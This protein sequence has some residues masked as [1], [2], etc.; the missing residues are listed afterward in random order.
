VGNLYKDI[1]IGTGAGL[2]VDFSYAIVIRFDFGIPLKK[3]YPTKNNSG[4]YIGEWTLGDSRWRR[5]NIIWNI[6]IGYPF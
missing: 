2:R 4:W 5:D 1:A 6:A 3:P